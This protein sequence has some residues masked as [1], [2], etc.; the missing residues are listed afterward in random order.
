MKASSVVSSPTSIV[1]MRGPR[2]ESREALAMEYRIAARMAPTRGEPGV[3]PSVLV[4]VTRAS[5][6]W[7]PP[8]ASS[9]APS[10]AAELDSAGIGRP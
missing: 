5:G 3:L 2:R 7:R 4:R 1:A 10:S 6:A 9:S 8:P